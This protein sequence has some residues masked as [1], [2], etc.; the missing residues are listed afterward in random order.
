MANVIK[1]KKSS[2]AS[3][4]PTTSSLADGEMAV[5]TAD[6]KLYVRD[7]AS[8]VEVANAIGGGG[9][10]RTI[11][12]QVF[13][14]SGTFTPS[15]ALLDSGGMVEVLLV[16]G[17]GGGRS[18]GPPVGGSGGMVLKRVVQVT[19]ARS[20]TIGAGAS[21][22]ADGGA[23]SFGDL[24]ALGG[25]ADGLPCGEGSGTGATF[26]Q[27]PG[28][29]RANTSGAYGFGAGGYREW[30]GVST[31]PNTGRGGDAGVGASSGICIV[32]WWE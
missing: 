3:A 5:N 15:Q 14:T 23:S 9:S 30:P 16:G 19:A 4:V 7:G 32:T 21:T 13:T 18:S 1:P 24:V 22:G 10:S 20:V 25:R 17:G 27:A 8:I 31:P 11:K 26:G 6:K 2:T 28:L 29:V 12:Q